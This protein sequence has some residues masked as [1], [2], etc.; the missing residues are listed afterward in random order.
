MMVFVGKSGWMGGVIFSRGFWV[1]CY[2]RV[3]TLGGGEM[4]T[5]PWLGVGTLGDGAV[6]TLEGAC[7]MCFVVIAFLKICANSFIAF[8]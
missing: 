4:G 1:R 6:P 5:P 2:S 3:G 7:A 8:N